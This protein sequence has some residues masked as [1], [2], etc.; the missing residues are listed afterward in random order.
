MRVFTLL[1]LGGASLVAMGA[2]SAFAE[3]N[4]EEI[5]QRLKRQADS[6][7]TM[8]IDSG[9]TTRG[10]KLNYGT[11]EPSPGAAETSTPAAA[12]VPAATAV[13]TPA[14]S[15]AAPASVDVSATVPSFERVD[16]P[17]PVAAA[18]PTYEDTTSEPSVSV[19]SV[20]EPSVPSV[21]ATVSTAPVSVAA[22]PV[23]SVPS[24]QPAPSFSFQ[25]VTPAPQA[26]PAP[27]L[28][29]VAPEAE[30][31]SSV[32]EDARIDLKVYFEWNSA[33]LRPQA[34]GQLAELCTAIQAMTAE[35]SN[36]FKIIGHT[37]KSGDAAYNLYLSNARAR[38]VKR[39]LIEEC[40]LPE[41]AL[42]AT[43]EGE[44]QSSPSAPS[45]APEER[46]V[47][48]QLVS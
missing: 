45:Q 43:G 42:I 38:E 2:T 3:M 20:A 19:S 44:R 12:A 7:G 41:S 37:D 4:S 18:A 40:S 25:D 1:A 9:S 29:A 47:E 10:M 23:Q 5:L 35:G 26:A 48:V 15:V 34:I 39:H 28:A 36:R 22:A 24:T 14:P 30:T 21:P 31:Y 13:M 33:A 11:A 8:Q 46:R 6:V 17:L 32:Q 27:Q 16:T